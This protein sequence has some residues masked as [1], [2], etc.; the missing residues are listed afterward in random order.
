M[1][2]VAII[3]ELYENFARGNVPAVLG[4]LDPAIEWFEA[5]GYPNVGGRHTG[6]AGVLDALTRVGADWN[7]LTLKP[8]DFIG[9]GSLVIVLGAVS[10]TSRHSGKSFHSRFAH[11]WRLRDSLVTLWRAHLDTALVQ[12]AAKADVPPAK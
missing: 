12:A 6:H 11:E 4:G 8:E 5:E 1:G 7:Q 9:D 2:N 10:G 3:K